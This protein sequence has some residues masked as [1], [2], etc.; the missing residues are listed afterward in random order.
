MKRPISPQFNILTPGRFTL[1][2]RDY[3]ELDPYDQ[4][5]LHTLDVTPEEGGFTTIRNRLTTAFR[6]LARHPQSTQDEHNPHEQINA[7]TTHSLYKGLHSGRGTDPLVSMSR[8][9]SG[10]IIDFA[11]TVQWHRLDPANT[12][13]EESFAAGFSL[14]A[15]T[16]TV[17]A[18]PANRDVPLFLL[19]Y[20]DTEFSVLD[21]QSGAVR[22]LAQAMHTLASIEGVVNEAP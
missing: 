3:Y 16:I 7:Y 4:S 19:D 14:R 11:G 8:F 12:S 17:S 22:S 1:D 18:R 21:I 20:P 6:A 5:V 2:A 10:P 15:S 9:V 13:S